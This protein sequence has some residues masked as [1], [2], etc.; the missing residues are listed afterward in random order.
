MFWVIGHLVSDLFDKFAD[1]LGRL[2]C[3]Q[4][5]HIA[6]IPPGTEHLIPLVVFHQQPGI[7][8]STINPR[9]ILNSR[10]VTSARHHRIQF[11]NYFSPGIHK[12]PIR[13]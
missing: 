9:K 3:S 4:F 10:W 7:S 5:E 1:V 2:F 13:N 11:A 6:A 12:S 8:P